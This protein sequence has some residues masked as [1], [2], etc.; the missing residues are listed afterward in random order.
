MTMTHASAAPDVVA[1]TQGVPYLEWGPVFA[2]ATA[3]ASISFLLLS[4]GT[5]VGLSLTWQP[6]LFGLG[7]LT[8]ARH[9]EGIVEHGKRTSLAAV[10][11]LLDRRTGETTRA[12]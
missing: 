1:R 7:A 11:R 8:F 9:P 10:Q 12:T 4:F 5:S 3:A 6:V 2:G